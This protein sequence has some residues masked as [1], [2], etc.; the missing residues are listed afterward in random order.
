M[1]TLRRAI[2][3]YRGELGGPHGLRYEVGHKYDF[4]SL[5]KGSVMR[6]SELLRI[7]LGDQNLRV[8]TISRH[9]LSK[10]L[11]RLWSGRYHL[12]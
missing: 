1:Y 4:E 12:G 2:F 8:H 10:V 6:R 3:K 7:N 5:L 11:D 9:V